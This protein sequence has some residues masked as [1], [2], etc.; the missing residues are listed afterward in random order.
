M[1]G[2]WDIYQAIQVQPSTEAP[3]RLSSAT[4]GMEQVCGAGYIESRA[5]AICPEGYICVA[6]MLEQQISFPHKSV[7]VP[8]ETAL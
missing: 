1:Q 8:S 7:N 3:W 4:G 6:I 2:P 5:S